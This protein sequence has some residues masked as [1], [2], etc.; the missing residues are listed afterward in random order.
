MFL[1]YGKPSP[2]QIPVLWL[3]LSRS[4]ETVQSVYFCFGAKPANSKICNQDS[5]KKS[6]KIVILHIETAEAK[7]LK[8]FRNFKD[9]WRRQTFFKCKPLEVHLLSGT[10]CH[11]MNYLL[12][13]LARAVPGN[14]SPQ[15]FSHRPRCTR[16]V[17]SQPRA[18]IPQYGPRT[19]LVR[20]Y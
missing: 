2:R 4:M 12:T 1:L 19:R 9:G 15:S 3:V 6:M 18:N 8:F 5:E 16:S 17:L 11:I 20:G 10:E 14:I 7:R 13:E